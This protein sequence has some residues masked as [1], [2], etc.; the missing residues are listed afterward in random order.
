MCMDILE[1]LIWS[2][3]L[4]SLTELATSK[5]IKNIQFN[6]AYLNINSTK[7]VLSF[8]Y[9]NNLRQRTVLISKH[10]KLRKLKFQLAYL[11]I[12]ST[13]SVLFCLF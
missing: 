4:P 3:S 2:C 10:R 8:A 12:N 6:L 5:I 1:I 7:T 13:K 9:L 11:N